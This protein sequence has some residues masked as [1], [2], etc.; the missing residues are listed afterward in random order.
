MRFMLWR[1]Q[2]NEKV[3]VVIGKKKKDMMLVWAREQEE[4]LEIEDSKI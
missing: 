3:L 4:G 1:Q 2:I